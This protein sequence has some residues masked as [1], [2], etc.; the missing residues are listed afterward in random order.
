MADFMKAFKC[1]CAFIL[2]WKLPCIHNDR[3]SSLFLPRAGQ[4]LEHVL[5]LE[6]VHFQMPSVCDGGAESGD[7]EELSLYCLS[8]RNS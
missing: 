2:V 7:L 4:L 1:E 6:Q 8:E 3:K 5:V